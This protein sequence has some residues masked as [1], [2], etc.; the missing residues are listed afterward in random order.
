MRSGYV[1]LR[2]A[3]GPGV[4]TRLQDAQRHSCAIS[5]FFLRVPW[6]VRLCPPQCGQASGTLEV[7]GTRAMRGMGDI[8][9]IVCAHRTM[10]LTEIERRAHGNWTTRRSR[11]LT[12]FARPGREVEP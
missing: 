4:K 3:A 9:L 1:L 5:S 2:S 10:V 6:R 12:V 7:I 8:L 11:I